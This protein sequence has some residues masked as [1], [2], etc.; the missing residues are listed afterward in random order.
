MRALFSVPERRLYLV[1]TAVSSVGDRVL[2]L[3]MGIW[4]KTL[5]GSN[6]AA[7][8]TFFFFVAPSLL[9]PLAGTLVDRLPRRRLLITVNL[10]TAAVVCSLVLVHGRGEVWL[11]Y[12]V[13]ALYGAGATVLSAGGS[14]MLALIFRGE[15][16]GEANAFSSTV[17]EGCRLFAPLAGAGLFTLIGGAALGLF[18][19]ATFLFAAGTLASITVREPDTSPEQHP[20]WRGYTLA[21][22]N[23]LRHSVPLRQMTVAVAATLLLA[24]LLE[25]IGFA[26]VTD[27]LHRSPPF[28]G[29][30]V[31]LQGA[32][33]LAG[34]LAAARV[35]HRLGAGGLVAAGL[36]LMAIALLA[37]T[38][39]TLTAVI[40]GMLLAGVG[41]PW[42]LVGY[43][44]ALQRLTPNALLGRVDAAA[45]L[46]LGA[47]QAVS[48]AG[49]AALITVVNYRIL[50]VSI[51]AVVAMSAVWLVT[52][53]E[54]RRA[55]LETAV[56]AV[57]GAQ[58]A[59][60]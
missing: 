50:L 60:A 42:L 40:P 37:L 47:P 1:G 39:P 28:L 56:A 45:S 46:L 54:Q 4:V 51:A 48:I 43:N 41:V 15:Q 44:T 30:L 11:I 19:A 33:A 34:A 25:S 24:G 29:V 31:S 36:G 12:L 32:G 26:V 38:A 27:G 10:L 58:Q 18:D 13:M 23:Y 53:R 2:F 14:A 17:S 16:L 6:G 55:H 8:L 20:S 21:G 59:P 7:G 49:G 57:Q 35:M 52:R 22:I 5:T 3:A 9:S